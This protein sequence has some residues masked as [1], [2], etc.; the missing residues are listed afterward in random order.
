[1]TVA[2]N[3]YVP[4]LRTLNSAGGI[5]RASQQLQADGTGQQV[6]VF[7][8][9]CRVNY[10]PEFYGPRLYADYHLA[11]DLIGYRPTIT[12]DFSLLEMDSTRALGSY[13]LSLIMAFYGDGIR[14]ANYN[15]AQGLQFNLYGASMFSDWRFVCPTSPWAPIP[16]GG[17]QTSP[18]AELTMTLQ[19]RDLLTDLLP[20]TNSW[21]GYRW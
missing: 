15:P 11:L 9:S 13:G 20:T 14:M 3:K 6:G 5:L 4:S 12:L 16:A 17:V 1:M 10:V 18:G 2:F 8:K 21:E 19:C 7:L